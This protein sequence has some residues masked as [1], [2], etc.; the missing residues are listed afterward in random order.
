LTQLSHFYRGDVA[1]SASAQTSGSQACSNRYPNQGNDSVI[2]PPIK[3]FRISGRKF[4]LQW[5][6]RIQNNSGFSFA[7]PP[8]ESHITLVG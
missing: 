8:E 2:L 6:L 5:P 1:L 4:L 7:L 3:I